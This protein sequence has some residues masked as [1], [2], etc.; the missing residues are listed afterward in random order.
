[1]RKSSFAAGFAA[2]SEIACIIVQ[3]HAIVGEEHA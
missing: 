2:V 1:V 3:L